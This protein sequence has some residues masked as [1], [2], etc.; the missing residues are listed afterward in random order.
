MNRI[1]IHN[2]LSPFS[3][4]YGIGVNLRNKLFDRRILPGEEFSIPVI[5]IGN[6][7]AGGTGKTPHT[8]YL[9]RLLKDKYRIA[10]LSRGYKRQTKNFILANEQAS[11]KTIGD[12]PFQMYRKFPDIIV[13]VDANR[14]RAINHLLALPDDKR[15]EIIL[16]DDAFQHR[17]VKPSLSIL[18]TNYSRPFYDDSLLPS[19]LLREP[20][21]NHVRADMV[22]CTKCPNSLNPIDFQTVKLNMELL[23]FQSLFFSSFHYKSLRPVFP[24]L[25][26]IKKE[27]IDRLKKEHYSFLLITGLANPTELINHVSNYTDDL[28]TLIYPD[29][30]SF[31]SKNIQNIIDRFRSIKNKN[32]IIITSEKDAVRLLDNEDIPEEIKKSLY[33]LPIE[34]VFLSD[35]ETLFKQKIESHVKE[36]ARNRIMA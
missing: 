33:Y 28:R 5:S 35:Q 16:L 6:L 3:F 11:A 19:G 15:P 24:E 36:F 14:R 25:V 10:V 1:K 9:I 7:T 12:E 22:V 23:P 18:L 17:Y 20:W 2:Y 34:V 27:S 29:H 8:E 13:A 32:K 26:S 21:K 30:H 4:L 31:T